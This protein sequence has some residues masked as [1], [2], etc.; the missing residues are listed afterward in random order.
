MHALYKSLSPVGVIGMQ[1]GMA[2]FGNDPADQF[3]S[4]KWRSSLIATLE[5]TGFKSIHVYED[6][7]C[8][9][10]GPV[11]FLVASKDELSSSKELWIRSSALMELEIRKR[12]Y[13]ASELPSLSLQY[14]DSGV[15]GNFF[16]P[17]K[18]FEI[19][20]C[21]SIPI[22]K[23]CSYTFHERLGDI[24]L[25]T[26]DVHPSTVGDGSGRG[27][28]TTVN[29]KKGSIIGRDARRVVFYPSSVKTI[30]E[31]MKV[32]KTQLDVYK[33]LDGYGWQSH[34]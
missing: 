1:L 4:R 17:H 21:R 24:P 23:S 15:M 6:A 29:I 9:L 12:M 31:Y 28:F 2:P 14:F 8:A 25:S 19:V 11:L 33:Y 20:F 5:Q 7:N 34:L 10:G 13:V 32:S 27:V 26:L 3:T 18:S 30:F 22:P 16:N